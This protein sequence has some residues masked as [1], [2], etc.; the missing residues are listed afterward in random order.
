[1][2][3]STKMNIHSLE[4]RENRLRTPIISKRKN[5][6]EKFLEDTQMAN[7]QHMKKFLTLLV[8]QRTIYPGNSPSLLC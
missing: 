2:Y 3:K 4:C 8:C 6:I 7:K 5:S 1:M